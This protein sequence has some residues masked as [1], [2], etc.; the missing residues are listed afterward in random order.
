MFNFQDQPDFMPFFQIYFC[1]NSGNFWTWGVPM[2][3][4]E[5]MDISWCVFWI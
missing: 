1:W 4:D 3:I 2:W 5:R